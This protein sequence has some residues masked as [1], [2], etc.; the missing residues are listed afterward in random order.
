MM[1]FLIA[2]DHA[3]VRFG[4]K[5]VILDMFPLAMVTE[6]ATFDETLQATEKQVYDLLIL[7]TNLPGGNNLVMLDTIKLRQPAICILVFSAFDEKVYALKYLQAGADG[8]LDK[9]AP[10]TEIKNA[11]Q[12]VLR[13]EKYMSANTREQL[14]FSANKKT[15][16]NPLTD[17]SSREAAVLQLLVQGLPVQKIA[18]TL[19]L[20]ISTVS[21]Y[22]NRI[23][24]KLEVSNLVE[25][26]QKI[27]LYNTD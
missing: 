1:N 9:A 26:L 2:D 17:L 23:F 7:D 25:L 19:E 16:H 4:V 20:H 18:A 12:T 21:T 14:L 11:I 13:N 27:E 5:Q 15:I 22:K 10:D 8:Y 3:I 6:A 24:T